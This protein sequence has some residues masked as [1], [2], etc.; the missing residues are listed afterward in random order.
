MLIVTASMNSSCAHQLINPDW[1][2]F[3]ETQEEAV[4]IA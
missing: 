1:T 3:P 4:T 2:K